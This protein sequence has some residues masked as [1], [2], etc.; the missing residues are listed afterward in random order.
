MKRTILILAALCSFA[1]GCASAHLD[2][3]AGFAAFDDN[4]A[5]DF[6]ASDGEGVVLAVR[7]EKNRPHGDLSYWTSALDVQLREAGYRPH[8]VA[9]VTS[10]DGHE[11]KQLRYVVDDDGRELVFWVSVF[12]TDRHVVLV[13]AGGDVAFF[14]PKERQIVAAIATLQVG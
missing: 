9:D 14:E 6:Y 8:N 3:P 5:Y 7:T 13:E 2:T 1:G 12:V 10:A 11:G 4:K